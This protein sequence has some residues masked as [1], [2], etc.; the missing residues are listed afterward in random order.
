M[1]AANRVGTQPIS[2]ESA[3]TVSSFIFEFT[4]HR[5]TSI[6][7]LGKPDLCNIRPSYIMAVIRTLPSLETKAAW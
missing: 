3:V 1:T 6:A 2:A 4:F 5:L 7:R